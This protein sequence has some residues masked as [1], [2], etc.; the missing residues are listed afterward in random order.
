MSGRLD[1]GF[2]GGVA[3]PGAIAAQVK[4][5]TG[6][7]SFEHAPLLARL[8][9]HLVDRTLAGE[10]RELQEYALGVSIFNRG[11]SFDPR[12]DNIVRA[13]ARRLRQRLDAYY[14]GDGRDDPIV[15]ELP[16]GHYVVR[17]SASGPVPRTGPLGAAADNGA[18]LKPR[19]SISRP[20]RNRLLA[21]GL[22]GVTVSIGVFAWRLDTDRFPTSDTRVLRVGEFTTHGDERVY[23]D[24]ADGLR[25]ELVRILSNIATLVVTRDPNA[26]GY[27]LSGTLQPLA[28]DRLRVTAT[29]VDAA[30]RTIWSK[31][32]DASHTDPIASEA[33]VATRIARL[34]FVLLRDI[35]LESNDPNARLAFQRGVAALMSFRIED[36]REALTY[37]NQALS[38]D[39]EFSHAWVA[40]ANA[41]LMLGNYGGMD[42][43][44]AAAEM[45]AARDAVLKLDPHRADALLLD[46]QLKLYDA[47]FPGAEESVRLARAFDRGSMTVAMGRGYYYNMCGRFDEA[48]ASVQPVLDAT[49]LWEQPKYLRIQA[50]MYAGRVAEALAMAD[51]ILAATPADRRVR[52]LR[53]LTLWSD[54]RLDDALAD[55]PMLAPTDELRTAVHRDGTAALARALFERARSIE[56]GRSTRP[57]NYIWRY[58][59]TGHVLQGDVEEAI[60]WL[61]EGWERGD[62]WEVL[63]LRQYPI[64]G[65]AAFLNKPAAKAALK[66]LIGDPPTCPAAAARG[67]QA[68]A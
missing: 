44:D 67:S 51:E 20:A 40:K 65:F 32:F 24:A 1:N 59:F 38:I 27:A 28:D 3:T 53:A 50:L 21:A 47:D 16:K 6:H 2:D 68:G 29:L 43:R 15:I 11:A 42:M 54:G 33:E 13:N 57:K 46:A 63:A 18:P 60:R 48:L 35:R 17:I 52:D 19:L 49:S 9:R 12:A 10:L 30:G 56:H 4:Q 22:I 23:R 41:Y 5:I 66:E 7:P 14:Q 39:P 34:L 31:N 55:F 64:P 62:R 37:L 45:R 58:Y 25:D 61:R 36:A 8:L 26:R